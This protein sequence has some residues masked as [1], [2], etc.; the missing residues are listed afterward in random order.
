MISAGKRKKLFHRY[1]LSGLFILLALLAATAGVAACGGGSGGGGGT[2]TGPQSATGTLT[3]TA[4]GSTGS[5]SQTAQ[6]AITVD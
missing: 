3:I 4:A 2:T 6:V 5:I 1:H